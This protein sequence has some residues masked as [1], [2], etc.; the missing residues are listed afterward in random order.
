MRMK[1]NFFVSAGQNQPTEAVDMTLTQIFGRWGSNEG[2]KQVLPL[3][4]IT[5]LGS[6]VRQHLQALSN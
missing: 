3:F 2:Q 6:L 5:Y 1:F 4:L